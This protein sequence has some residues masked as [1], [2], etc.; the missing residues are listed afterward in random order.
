MYRKPCVVSCPPAR[1]PP[2]AAADALTLSLTRTY[3]HLLT[4]SHARTQKHSLD[5]EEL[6]KHTLTAPY[7]P[8]IQSHTDSSNFRQDGEEMEDEGVEQYF[9]DS[10]WCK[11]F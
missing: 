6:E 8:K 9:G 1:L 4:N 10:E 11:G 2:T 7:K 3:A 5:K